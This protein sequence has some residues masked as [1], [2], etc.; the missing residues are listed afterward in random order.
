MIPFRHPP[1]SIRVHRPPEPWKYLFSAIDPPP[2]AS[3]RPRMEAWDEQSEAAKSLRTSLA[4]RSELVTTVGMLWRERESTL[5]S[6]YDFF[7]GAAGSVE[8]RKA[9][10]NN[11]RQYQQ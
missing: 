6:K 10:G 9:G 3:V 1:S 7:D 4:R 8:S 2:K 11:G 5:C